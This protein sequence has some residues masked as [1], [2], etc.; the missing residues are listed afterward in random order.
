MT[1][2]ARMATGS[3]PMPMYTAMT[4]PEMVAIPPIIR[5]SSSDRVIVST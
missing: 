2:V 5:A 3:A 1:L 4:P